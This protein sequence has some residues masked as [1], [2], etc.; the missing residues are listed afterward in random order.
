MIGPLYTMY[1]VVALFIGKRVTD[2]V[3]EGFESKKIVH[4][5]F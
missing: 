4:I 2:Y 1:T 3:L 5:F